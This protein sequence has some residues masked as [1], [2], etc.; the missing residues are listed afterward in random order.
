M[1]D[2]ASINTHSSEVVLYDNPDHNL[3]KIVLN[4]SGVSICT[5][6]HLFAFNFYDEVKQ[7]SVSSKKF[8]KLS[9]ILYILR[10]L[11]SWKLIPNVILGVATHYINIYS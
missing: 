7:L 4:Y 1:D 5:Y 3:Y 2:G 11:Q 6:L 9:Y 10:H 8:E